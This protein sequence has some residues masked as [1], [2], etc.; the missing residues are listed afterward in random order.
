MQVCQ[1]RE[2]PRLRWRWRVAQLPPGGDERRP[3][4]HDSAAGVYVIFDNHIFPR[5]IKYVWSATVPEGTR[6]QNPLYWRAKM[7]VL[8]SGPSGLG[9]W[10]QEMEKRTA[11]HSALSLPTWNKAFI[12]ASLYLGLVS[13]EQQRWR[14]SGFSCARRSSI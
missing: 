9:E 12:T 2:F 10:H 5:V 13:R 4:T 3:E 7:V 6:L 14:T 1:P 11:R 8:R